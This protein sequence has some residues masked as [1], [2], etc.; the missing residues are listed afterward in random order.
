MGNLCAALGPAR[1]PCRAAHVEL[2]GLSIRRTHHS[3]IRRVD[4]YESDSYTTP[5]DRVHRT[6]GRALVP[7]S[8]LYMSRVTLRKKR[9][10]RSTFRFATAV[11]GARPASAASH[12]ALHA[13]MLSEKRGGLVHIGEE[14]GRLRGTKQHDEPVH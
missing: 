5:S 9:T 13:H 7:Y 1:L 14:A 12:I 11:T 8:L 4:D 10:R 3:K 6:R 2:E